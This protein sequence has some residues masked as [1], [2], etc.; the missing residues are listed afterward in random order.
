MDADR[1]IRPAIEV[2]AL[3]RV[4]NLHLVEIGNAEVEHQSP[5]GTL[6]EFAGD[7][8]IAE[9]LEF[10]AEL[11][12]N[13]RRDLDLLRLGLCGRRQ[14]ECHEHSGKENSF[15]EL[16]VPFNRVHRHGS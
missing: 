3:A 4:V 6:V 12:A 2:S 5:S 1:R 15:H 9:L 8:F 14:D 13:E 16:R 10:T 7:R 11:V